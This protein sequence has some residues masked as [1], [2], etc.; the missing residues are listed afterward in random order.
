MRRGRKKK[1]PCERA[2]EAK[3]RERLVAHWE[4]PSD[5]DA[6]AREL[7][8]TVANELARTN[9]VLESDRVLVVQYVRAVLLLD[10]TLREVEATGDERG[11]QVAAKLATT[12]TALRRQLGLS[13]RKA[14]E[15]AITPPKTK[16]EEELERLL[17]GY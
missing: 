8:W 12:M 13:E 2:A 17:N 14:R 10:R 11:V 16:E 15:K 4:P 7:F 1:L 5:F 3:E 6:E 9:R